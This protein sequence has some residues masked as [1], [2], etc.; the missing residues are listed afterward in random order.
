MRFLRLLE[1]SFVRQYNDLAYICNQL[2]RHDRV[3]DSAG[4]VFLKAIRRMPR[5]VEDAVADIA[6]QFGPCDVSIVRSDFEDFLADLE[7][8]MFIATGSTTEELNTKE[9]R[10]RYGSAMVNYKEVTKSFWD[11]ATEPGLKS[12]QGLLQEHCA[13]N[14]TLID[15]QIE[16]T[17]KCNERCQHCYLPPNRDKTTLDTG[18]VVRLLDDFRS[19][20]GISITFS[21][22]E[23]LLHPDLPTFLRRSRVND[24]AITILSNATLLTEPLVDVIREVNIS[25]MQ[26]SIYSMD[27]NEHDHITGMTGSLSQ[28]LAAI[29]KL[30]AA[31]IPLQISCPVM[32]TNYRSY[33]A[34]LKWANDKG[35]K[36]YTDYILVAR[37]D[38]TT[39]NLKERLGEPELRPLITAIVKHDTDYQDETDTRAQEVRKSMTNTRDPNAQ[40]CG[41]GRSTLCLSSSGRYYPCSSWRGMEVGSAITTSLRDV[42]DNSEELKQVRGITWGSFPQC[43]SCHDFDY[44]AMCMARN[45]NEGE[46]DMY[47]INEHFC[48][49]ARMNKAIVDQHNADKGRN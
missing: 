8:D 18:L 22:G 21:G 23:P 31:N 19:M 7:S 6:S 36:A 49:A 25:V 46:G 34:V 43:L 38:Q 40:V 47:K 15:F 24:L 16:L 27:A 4:G 48:M 11:P 28:S 37:S 32:M 3:Y 1:S 39:D 30:M 2:T 14:P 12:S 44:C 45:F 9:P 13:I 17:S 29:D 42:W 35:L 10:F 33:P 5:T 41:V 26:I 20:G